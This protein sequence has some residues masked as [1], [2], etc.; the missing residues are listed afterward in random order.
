MQV[1]FFFCTMLLKSISNHR[2]NHSWTNNITWLDRR[3]PT[4]R[5][6]ESRKL[7]FQFGFVMFNLTYPQ[8]WLWMT[9]CSVSWPSKSVTEIVR[10]QLS[11]NVF[12]T[13]NAWNTND[14]QNKKYNT[15]YNESKSN[16]IKASYWEPKICHRW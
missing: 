12:I 1:I 2:F 8:C 14:E 7:S 15:Q 5:S 6:Q 11:K 10:A 16:W 9:N 4:C 13:S 3:I